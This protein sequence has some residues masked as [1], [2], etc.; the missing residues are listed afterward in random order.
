[1]KTKKIDFLKWYFNGTININD[2]NELLEELE[3]Y[4]DDMFLKEEIEDFIKNLDEE[5]IIE[6]AE[7]GKYECG[8]KYKIHF[9]NKY[10]EMI[11]TEFYK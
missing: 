8:V 1:M 7:I 10:F 2:Q 5:I 11:G 9:G 3:L 4:Y 6:Q